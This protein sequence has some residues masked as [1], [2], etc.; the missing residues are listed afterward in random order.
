MIIFLHEHW[1]DNKLGV[2]LHQGV[3][4]IWDGSFN[5]SV[6]ILNQGK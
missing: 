2:Y 4:H 6:L 5:S 1:S 3:F